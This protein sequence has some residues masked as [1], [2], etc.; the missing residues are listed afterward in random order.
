[1]SQH[2]E[3][4]PQGPLWLFSVAERGLPGPMKLLLAKP[5]AGLD[6]AAWEGPVL[7]AAGLPGEMP[8]HQ[9]AR[10]LVISPRGP[11]PPVLATHL[12]RMTQAT[13]LGP[14]A[15]ALESASQR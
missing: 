9:P 10:R 14:P 15:P 11:E 4:L 5:L 3:L 1:M 7:L 2:P 13:D 6:T 12:D 8:T